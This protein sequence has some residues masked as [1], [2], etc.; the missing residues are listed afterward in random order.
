MTMVGGGTAAG[1]AI[2]LLV[3]PLLTRLYPPDVYGQASIFLAL[4]AVLVPTLTLTLPLGLVLPRTDHEARHL[5]AASVLFATVSAAIVSL[6]AAL[7][8]AEVSNLT[9]I[10][11]PAVFIWMIIPATLAGSLQLIGQQWL[12]R[13]RSYRASS[14]SS[15]FGAIAGAIV[16]VGFGLLLPISAGLVAGN[17]TTNV[18]QG[19]PA[20]MHRGLTGSGLLPRIR[21][22][23]RRLRYLVLRYRDF[24]RFRM[25][26][27]L[28][29][30]G[31]SSL[32]II[33]LGS[34]NPEAAGFF[35]LAK[36]I[37]D[38][39]TTLIGKAVADVLNPRIVDTIRSGRSI[40]PLLIKST[41]LLVAI[42]LP[43]FGLVFLF[44]PAL[45]KVIFGPRWEQAGEYASWLSVWMF[46]G[47]ANRPTVTASVP[48]NI[49]GVLL[50]YEVIATGMK[51]VALYVGLTLYSDIHFAV[52]LF[53]IF[54]AISYLGLIVWILLAARRHDLTSM[55]MTQ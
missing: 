13:R 41:A 50:A 19:I 27:L 44:G 53:C 28:L 52:K 29:N 5:A 16:R 34:T 39:P 55:R 21:L 10:R 9:G 6:I 36:T 54:G 47:F 31:S 14:F 33:A 23:T 4:V 35:A 17:A 8:S 38:A 11:E 40:S 26:Q 20:L 42:G 43:M 30:T 18:V 46:F 1:Q 15:I 25:P 3:A 24:V 45:F 7:F 22:T 49:Q 2:T 48:L 51:I 37:V 32:P 12:I